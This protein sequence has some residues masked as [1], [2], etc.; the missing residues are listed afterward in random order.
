MGTESLTTFGGIRFSVSARDGRIVLST[1]CFIGAA[2]GRSDEARRLAEQFSRKTLTFEPL[3]DSSCVSVDG[4][5]TAFASS[6]WIRSMAELF[7]DREE[8]ARLLRFDADAEKPMRADVSDTAFM[9]SFLLD[10][11]DPMRKKGPGNDLM[12]ALAGLFQLES[13]DGAEGKK[14][15]E[16]FAALFTNALY[17]AYLMD[18]KLEP[19]RWQAVRNVL[20]RLGEIY[21]V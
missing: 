5:I 17:R 15:T 11:I 3:V 14:R 18:L 1:P 10:R 7:S 4:R 16:R 13:A 12:C 20:L 19:L 8:T 2:S 6:E 9:V 21:R